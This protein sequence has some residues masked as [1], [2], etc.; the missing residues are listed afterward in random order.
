M[1]KLLRCAALV[2][3]C[4]IGLSSASAQEN[5]DAVGTWFGWSAGNTPIMWTFH[6]DGT[7][8]SSDSAAAGVAV[9]PGRDPVFVGVQTPWYGSWKQADDG[10]INTYQMKF[11]FEGTGSELPGRL[12]AIT[13][14][15]GHFTPADGTYLYCV[16]SVN[17]PGG[18]FD[19]EATNPLDLPRVDVCT[20]DFKGLFVGTLH[21]ERFP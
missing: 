10:S 4:A 14:A 13:Q 2:A 18:L 3:A 5:A 1:K 8:I 7:M 12:K 21:L 11:E 6:A 15:V 19:P 17:V 9:R 20:K 16:E